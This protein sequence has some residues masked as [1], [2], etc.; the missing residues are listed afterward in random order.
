MRRGL[1]VVLAGAMIAFVVVG[2]PGASAIAGS[3]IVVNS[4]AD[5]ATAGDGLCTLPEAINNANA[6]AD[7][8]SG[9]CAAGSGDDSITFA[10]TVTGTITLASAL[11]TITDTAGLTID[12]PGGEHAHDQRR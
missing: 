12:G 1:V 11:P 9:D 5:T 3:T 10:S 2:V 6:N 4:L 8:T 7:T